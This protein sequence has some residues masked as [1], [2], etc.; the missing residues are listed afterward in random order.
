MD[1]ERSAC[2]PPNG[3]L[4][5]KVKAWVHAV[6][7]DSMHDYLEDEPYMSRIGFTV[8]GAQF[9]DAQG[10][11]PSCTRVQGEESDRPGDPVRF[12]RLYV[13]MRAHAVRG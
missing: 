1:S 4:F 11:S 13:L 3:G 10:I 12:L 7:T 9:R 5:P 2:H 6:T 8:A